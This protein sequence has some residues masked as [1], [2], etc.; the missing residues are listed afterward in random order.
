MKNK[1]L[2]RIFG[3]R[4][5]KTAK[6]RIS[7]EILFGSAQFRDY[8]QSMSNMLTPHRQIINFFHDEDSD[9]TA[10]TDGNRIT[11]NTA[12]DVIKNLSTQNQRA[13]A[14]AGMVAHECAHI[15]YSDFYLHREVINS[16]K[17]GFLYENE[18]FAASLVDPVEK[19]N[20]AEMEAALAEPPKRELFC[21][22]YSQLSNILADVHDEAEICKDYGGIIPP[23]INM[24]TESL[25]SLMPPFEKIEG[26]SDL[27]VI[28]QMTL[29]IARFDEII[30]LD[31]D[32]ALKD[33]RMKTV[34]AMRP[35][36]EAARIENNE[37]KRVQLINHCILILWPVVSKAINDAEN[38]ARQL[39]RLAQQM[40]EQTQNEQSGQ[41]GQ[42]GQGG[43]DEQNGQQSGQTQS[44]Q[45]QSGQSQSGQSGA[46]NQT[47]SQ[48]AQSGQNSSEN[49]T[50]NP[51]QDIIQNVLNQLM[52]GSQGTTQ[53]PK[54]QPRKPK[55]T[56]DSQTNSKSN[57]AENAGG[58]NSNDNASWSN[59]GADS[60][61]S[62]SSANDSQSDDTGN[63]SNSNSGDNGSQPN[64]AASS[65]ADTPNN[66]GSQSNGMKRT[67][68]SSSGGKGSQPNNGADSDSSSFNSNG[69][70]TN[71]I[72][73][74]GDSGSS[75][76]NSQLDD[77][78]TS[79][80]S[81]SRNSGTASDGSDE[82]SSSSQD[83]MSGANDN[84]SANSNDETATSELDDKTDKDGNSSEQEI[85]PSGNDSFASHPNSMNRSAAE[86]VFRAIKEQLADEMS[87]QRMEEAVEEQFTSDALL[88]VHAANQTSP[89]I[90]L[91]LRVI[92]MKNI[93]ESTKMEYDKIMQEVGPVSQRLQKR[94]ANII[95]DMREGGINRRKHFGRI[96]EA[97]KSYRVDGAFF[98]NKKLPQEL[99]DMAIAVLIDQSGSMAGGR[100]ETAKKAAI[101]LDDFATGLNIPI[102][103]TGHNTG[104]LSG[105][106]TILYLYSLFDRVTK[107]DSYRIAEMSTGGANRDG[108][109]INAV[110]AMLAKRP[111]EFKILII[112]SDGQPND[113]NYGGDL[114]EKDIQ[115][116]VCLAKHK[117]IQTF[118][119]AI[120]SDKERIQRIYGDGFLDVSDLSTLPKVLT[121]LI[122]K[123]MI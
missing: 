111:E 95:A 80:D 40:N 2:R 96:I 14:I 77:M 84:T 42:G 6:P 15:R 83:S 27:T 26:N 56:A 51:M 94:I 28:F 76:E 109:A 98:A 82:N 13:L 120:G 89:H 81:D 92:R 105:P 112:I 61:G 17:N 100:I 33:E 48:T 87:H 21:Y 60:D 29:G 119:A 74:A 25:R 121:H 19:A 72:G 118:A 73:K 68:G 123:R 32:K 104:N 71:G 54:N 41:G 115:E 55:S 91:P 52:Q 30:A 103:I 114:A 5:C 59:D 46:N 79:G 47:Q 36:L 75:N 16:L 90:G 45:S 108:M 44:G 43:Q 70:K 64:D 67:G 102:M 58:S 78:T 39:S 106:G 122:S 117:G 66:K 85:N 65:G 62:D 116:I 38:F 22:I 97:K 1:E 69:S 86:A 23:G 35:Y 88:E 37:L 34:V 113:Y 50:P 24:T 7:D 11:I 20:Y 10:F 63:T 49:G 4:A 99:P 101:L 107:N 9:V 110:M 53:Q 3:Q 18:E 31:E 93:R 8:I 57:D 12:N